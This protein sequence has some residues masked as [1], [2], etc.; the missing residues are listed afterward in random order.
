MNTIVFIAVVAKTI[1][2]VNAI[3]TAVN[4]QI[5]CRQC[6]IVKLRH[7][8]VLVDILNMLKV[9]VGRHR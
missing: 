7:I 2:A 8:R 9:L 1:A 4:S 6:S 5:G 3:I